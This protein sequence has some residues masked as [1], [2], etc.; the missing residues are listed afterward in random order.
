MEDLEKLFKFI[1]V[2][3]TRRIAIL[4]LGTVLAFFGFTAEQCSWIDPEW[5]EHLQE[6]VIEEP[7]NTDS[8]TEESE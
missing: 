1:W 6:E 4:L 3:L 7:I 5:Q 8:I 2:L